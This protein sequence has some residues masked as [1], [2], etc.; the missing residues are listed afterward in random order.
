M[1]VKL[2]NANE[3]YKNSKIGKNAAIICYVTGLS[4]KTNN[5]FNWQITQYRNYMLNY[6]G[7]SNVYILNNKRNK[8]NNVFDDSY[9]IYDYAKE[10][11]LLDYN[12]DDVYSISLFYT[13]FGGVCVSD[14]YNVA[15]RVYE[16]IKSGR[17]DYFQIQDD[18]ELC[19]VNP[20]HY[21]DSR[22]TPL[23]MNFND[24]KDKYE[25][26]KIELDN[27]LD[28][29]VKIA[30]CGT[31]YEKFFNIIKESNKKIPNLTLPTTVK[32]WSR[33]NVFDY[34]CVN[35]Y[36]KNKLTDYD[37]NNRKYLTEYHGY[38]KTDK[39]RIK[40]TL[41]FYNEIKG[42]KLIISG[43]K[44][45]NE[46]FEYTDCIVNL[47][48]NDMLDYISKNCYSTFVTHNCNCYNDFMSPRYLD[49]MLVDNIAFVYYKYDE[50]KIMAVSDELKDFM[51]VKTPEEFKEKLNMVINDEKLYR[52]I[53]YLQRESIYI[54]YKDKMNDE[55]IKIFENYLKENE[56]YKY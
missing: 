45:F 3:L 18:P 19:S 27:F 36:L 31:Q 38:I 29:N 8:T 10:N 32:S 52:K 34:M 12:I 17:G 4:F 13:F 21:F 51:Y 16:F 54:L 15:C 24:A 50:N 5:I 39:E 35:T 46:N 53:K 26:I 14:Y 25:S 6:L 42:N 22:K 49:A 7:Y 20:V 47:S 48:Y 43:K 44:L 41:D 30:Y 23:K 1:K 11:V 9:V 28:K 40:V 55:S 56:K 2:N 33:F 37:F